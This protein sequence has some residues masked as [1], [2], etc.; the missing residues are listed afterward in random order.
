MSDTTKSEL[1][2]RVKQFLAA[3]PGYPSDELAWDEFYEMYSGI[4]ARF[5]RKRGVRKAQH[6]E[7]ALQEVWRGVVASFSTYDRSKG[8]FRRWLHAIVRKRAATYFANERKWNK[9]Q[10]LTSAIVKSLADPAAEDPSKA[11]ERGFDQELFRLAVRKL[12]MGAAPME[13]R[14]F[15]ERHLRK[16]PKSF[17]EIADELNTSEGAARSSLL[18]AKKKLRTILKDLIGRSDIWP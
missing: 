15:R 16:N 11:L 9:Q 7:E 3:Q 5:C 8:G 6:L 12:K 10:E 13:W 17:S 1:L 2:R 18:R 14:V 4:L